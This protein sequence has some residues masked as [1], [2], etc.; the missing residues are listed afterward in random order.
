MVSMEES[1]NNDGM[2]YDSE[3]GDNTD[4]VTL[5]NSQGYPKRKGEEICQFFQKNGTCKFAT[6]CK[7]DHPEYL[8]NDIDFNSLGFPLRPDMPDCEYY[9]KFQECKFGCTCKNNHPEVSKLN[10]G[11][12]ATGQAG[13]PHVVPKQRP[14]VGGNQARPQMSSAPAPFVQRGQNIQIAAT[15]SGPLPS[16]PGVQACSFYLKSG[17]CKYGANCKWDHPARSG[18]A[19]VPMMMQ[20]Q[21]PRPPMAQPAGM[22]DD[23]PVR[24]G[25]QA[26]AFFLKT[27]ECRFGATCK[28]D[29]SK[30]PAAQSMIKREPA[31]EPM[32]TAEPDGVNSKGYPLRDG[33]SPCSFFQKTGN[34]SYGPTCKWDHPEEYCSLS[35]NQSF[36]ETTPAPAKSTPQSTGLP[37]RPGLQACL[38]YMKTG[39]CSFGATCKWDHPIGQGGSESG[40]QRNA[41]LAPRSVPY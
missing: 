18:V 4:L 5:Y 41:G 14:N 22:V 3:L 26:C 19:A 29:H 31:M 36:M 15:P 17:I 7:W 9:S 10:K 23:H 20:T 12:L 33:V 16:R 24:P 21:M 28:W 27:G 13:I 37:S 39:A 32:I 35:E 11:S 6:T 2:M 1:F 34:C 30:R 8:Y 38:F 40:P 25:V